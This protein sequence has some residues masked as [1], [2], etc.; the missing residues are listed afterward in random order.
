MAFLHRLCLLCFLMLF[1]AA[2]ASTMGIPDNASK[3]RMTVPG[4]E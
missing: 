2:C 3:V 1:V 4:C